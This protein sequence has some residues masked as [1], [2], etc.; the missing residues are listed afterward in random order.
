MWG[1]LALAIG[2]EVTATMSLRSSQGFTHLVPSVVV[3]IGYS[4]SFYAL[5]QALV[6]GMPVATAYTIWCGIGISLITLLSAVLF[7][8]RPSPVQLAGII[9]VAIGV[10]TLQA[11]SA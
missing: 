1:W 6:R 10:V 5:S 8:E 7:D 4:F 2:S 9:L 11:G 3:V